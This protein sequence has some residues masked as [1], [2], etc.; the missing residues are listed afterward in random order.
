MAPLGPSDP[1]SLLGRLRAVPD[2]RRR[3]GRR[4][5]L[6]ALLGMLVLAALHGETSLRG[7]WL[8]A[9]VRWPQL[10]APL[11]FWTPQRP[12]RLTTVWKLLARL[13]HAAL[14][15][16]LGAW[17]ESVR[18]TAVQHVSVDGKTLRGSRRPAERA[19]HV[20][21]AVGQELA[22]VLRQHACAEGEELTTA[23]ALLREMPLA[24]RVVT[25]D[26]G[27]FQRTVAQTI[28]AGGGAYL[29]VLKGNHPEVKGAVDE[30]VAPHVAPPRELA[31]ARLPG[32]RQSPRPP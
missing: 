5:P 19:L 1:N 16:V 26:A 25:G 11:G 6:P 2:P 12:P 13:D 4:Y 7:M 22:V 27:L 32:K 18:G 10:W 28:V 24:G 15:R 8:W 21:E 9:A 23:L 29:G 14:E 3:Q 20:V 30:W 17:S 31:P